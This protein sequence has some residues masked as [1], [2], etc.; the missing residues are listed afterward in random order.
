MKRHMILAAS[1]TL[2]LL[3]GCEKA[4][5]PAP[6]DTATKTE[7]PAETV[8]P[9]DATT[10]HPVDPEADP[11]TAPQR[12]ASWAGKWTGVEGM[13]VNITPPQTEPYKQSK[14]DDRNTTGT[15]TQHDTPTNKH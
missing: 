3:A 9:V 10:A 8:P 7:I 13:Y 15:N 12:F 5:A 2:V 6:G 11:A 4:E 1:T 14:Q